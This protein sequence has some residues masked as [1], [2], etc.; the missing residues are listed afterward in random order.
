MATPDFIREI[1]AT[2]GHQL[3]F[4]PGVSAVVFDDEGQVLLG[5][6]ADTGK[7]SI[8]GGI[9]EPGEQPAVTAV[10]E[11]YEETAVQC[12]AE[13]VVLVQALRKPVTYPN[14]DQCQFMDIC[15]RCR[16]V[17]GQARVNDDES[18]EVGWFSADAL[19][20]LK[21]FSLFRIKQAQTEGPAWF[22]PTIEQ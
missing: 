1:R 13:R 22:E 5:R 14:G 21:E 19:P 11:V 4:L 18:L 2:A 7:W 10:R 9:P 6:R 16:A 8:I 3:L 17:G 15:I 20:E 12:V